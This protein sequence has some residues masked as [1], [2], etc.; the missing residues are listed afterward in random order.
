MRP[1]ERGAAVAWDLWQV[2]REA[3][4]WGPLDGGKRSCDE[5]H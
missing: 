5:K 2:E 4:R 1:R 3:E